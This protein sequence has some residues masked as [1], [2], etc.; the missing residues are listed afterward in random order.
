MLS[1]PNYYIDNELRVDRADTANGIGGGLLVYIRNDLI[2]KPVID[3][4][5]FEQYCK[6]QVFDKNDKNPINIALIYRSP[7]TTPENTLELAKILEKSEKRAMFLGDF[8]CPKLNINEGRSDNKSRPLLEAAQNSFLENMVDFST[9][10]CG[11]TLDLLLTN[12]SENIFNV[13]DLGNLGNSD[14]SIIK[15]ELEFSPKFNKS[16]QLVRD[17]RKGDEIGLCNFFSEIDFEQLLQN[18]DAN[19]SWLTLKDIIN[20]GLDRYIPL[21][22]RRRPGQPPWMTKKV[23]NSVNR[24]QRH[25]KRYKK[26]RTPAN[27]EQFKSSEKI[28]KKAVSDAKRRFEQ[29]IAKSG[30]KRPF[31]SYVK[32][33]SKTRS[34]VGPLKVDNKVISDNKGMAS[35]LNDFFLSVF[36]K[37]NLGNVPVPEKLPSA[38]VLSDMVISSAQVKK[39]LQNLKENSAPGPDGITPRV[40]KLNADALSGPLADIY[41]KSIQSGQVP[42]DLKQANVTPIFKKG[43][44]GSPGNYRPVSLTSVPCRVQESCM[45]D[46]IV[47]HLVTNALLKSTQH[48][49]MKHK[50]TTTNLLEFLE[51]LT[52]EMDD[53]NPMDVVY[54]DFSKA[55]DRVPHARLLAKFKAHSVDGKVLNWIG[56]WLN[57]RTQRTVLNGE[58]SDW[59]EVVSGVP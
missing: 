19:D 51:K 48:G 6:F 31:N 32:S 1:V 46:I 22:Q 14:H 21:M 41:N 18:K 36:R 52:T 9:H 42:S 2:V 50:S 39:K 5:I 11:N 57:G 23:K 45:K 38:S 7:N 25:W 43:V 29:N 20:Q 40:L 28:C 10:I 24:K 16:E 59:G 3:D 33:K 58:F 17:W 35:A 15:I 37:E 55:F 56:E 27:F 34:N 13:E 30:N 44:K 49:F 4:N 26:N 54:L 47:D 12:I 53:G 8:N